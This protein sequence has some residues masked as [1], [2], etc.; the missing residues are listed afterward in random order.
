MKKSVK[1]VLAVLGVVVAGV[2]VG[3]AS[4]S[5][6]GIHVSEGAKYQYQLINPDDI[7]IE[8]SGL[9]PDSKLSNYKGKYVTDTAMYLSD[10][11]GIYLGDEHFKAKVGEYI[12]YSD[13]NWTW[14]LSDFEM[15]QLMNSQG[16]AS[17]SLFKGVVVYSDGTEGDISADRVTLEPSAD[18]SQI[19]VGVWFRDDIFYYKINIQ[20]RWGDGESLS[21]EEKETFK[22]EGSS[23]GQE[24]YTDEVNGAISGK[25]YSEVDAPEMTNIDWGIFNEAAI[26]CLGE[27]CYVGDLFVKVGSDPRVDLV[28]VNNSFNKY[29]GNTLDKMCLFISDLYETYLRTQDEDG[30]FDILYVQPTNDNDANGMYDDLYKKYKSDLGEWGGYS[31]YAEQEAHGLYEQYMYSP[32]A[33]TFAIGGACLAEIYSHAYNDNDS[34]ASVKLEVLRI[35]DSLIKSNNSDLYSDYLSAVQE[36]IENRGEVEGLVYSDLIQ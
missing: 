12:K 8:Y 3:W 18:G 25:T 24:V 2:V 6:N 36:M 27:H 21:E 17:P 30:F 33:D 34:S 32:S 28:E 20:E 16:E 29:Y 5:P 7:I 26:E 13:I 19:V 31:S 35:Y 9:K 14:N 10:E 11:V 23:S 4:G 22:Q 15:Y 1:W